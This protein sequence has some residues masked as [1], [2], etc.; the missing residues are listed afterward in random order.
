[1]HLKAITLAVLLCV[2]SIQTSS[3]EGA[4]AG[5]GQPDDTECL[6]L[7]D[8]M[9]Q[10]KSP[11]RSKNK[12]CSKMVG[13]KFASRDGVLRVIEIQ[14][15]VKASTTMAKLGFERFIYLEKLY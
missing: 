2:S 5:G 8:V 1:M 13:V 7:K 4:D 15:K 6:L 9:A 3:T 14:M 11:G 10:V 12:E